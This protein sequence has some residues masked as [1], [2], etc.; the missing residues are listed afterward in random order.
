MPD[1]LPLLAEYCMSIP[2]GQSH[3][4]DK[5]ALRAVIHVLERYSEWDNPSLVPA[6]STI[7]RL[8][9]TQRCFEDISAQSNFLLKCLQALRSSSDSVSVFAARIFLSATQQQYQHKNFK[10]ETANKSI[11]LGSHLCVWLQRCTCIFVFVDSFL[12]L[13]FFIPGKRPLSTVSPTPL[14]TVG[15]GCNTFENL[16]PYLFGLISVCSIDSALSFILEFCRDDSRLLT[17]EVLFGV[18]DSAIHSRATTTDIQVRKTIIM[19]FLD[20]ID[21]LYSLTRS[22]SVS[23]V[24]FATNILIECHVNAPSKG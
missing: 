14:Y 5:N 10:A 21:F 23:L 11:I 19:R 4:N 12:C 22:R 16:N 17:V 6:F 3:C 8:L 24:K 18:L 20:H 13:S 2:R 1:P 15:F 9:S 7:E